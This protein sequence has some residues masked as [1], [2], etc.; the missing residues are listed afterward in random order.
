M[1]LSGIVVA[2]PLVIIKL[3]RVGRQ[4]PR[5][6]AIMVHFKRLKDVA[7]YTAR[8]ARLEGKCMSVVGPTITRNV[9]QVHQ[10][11][12]DHCVVVTARK[13]ICIRYGCTEY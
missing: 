5:L 4:Q 13:R 9:A 1:Y 2:L 8:N 12:V 11:V 3:L 7:G 10:L 6:G